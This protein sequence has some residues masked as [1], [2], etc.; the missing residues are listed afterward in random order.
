MNDHTETHDEARGL[1]SS[2]LEA[3]IA[4]ALCYSL[5]FLTGVLFLVTEKKSRFVRFHA[6]QSTVVFAALFV[7][8]VA[9]NYMPALAFL[10]S[11]IWL[12]TLG[13]WA[14]MMYKAYT[15]EHYPLP[16]VGDLAEKEL[17]KPLVA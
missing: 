12:A 10:A 2:G 15:W 6:M 3:N 16:L 4:G 5:G 8:Q 1:S 11:L 13:V 7:I 9:L 14:F 17:D